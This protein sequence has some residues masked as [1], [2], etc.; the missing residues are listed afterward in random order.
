MA[1]TSRPK[2]ERRSR[3]EIDRN[4]FFGDLF[5]K[6]GIAVLAAILCIA[7]LT[8]FTLRDALAEGQFAYLGLMSAFGVFGLGSYLTGRH[9]RR[10]A[11]HWDFD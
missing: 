4:Y 2:A 3:G 6:T 1:K 9:F 10:T 11:T 7:A 8:P 5:I